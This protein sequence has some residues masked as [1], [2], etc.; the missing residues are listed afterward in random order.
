MITTMTMSTA[1]AFNFNHYK[2]RGTRYINLE[3]VERRP[4]CGKST[5][6]YLTQLIHRPKKKDVSNFISRGDKYT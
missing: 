5:V 6:K 1:A 3:N 4:V 2:S